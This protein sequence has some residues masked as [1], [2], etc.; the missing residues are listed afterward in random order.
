MD[1]KE[2]QLHKISGIFLYLYPQDDVYLHVRAKDGDRNLLTFVTNLN[3]LN[4][5]SNIEHTEKITD[6]EGIGSYLTIKYQ[7]A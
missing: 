7:V 1:T 3:V 6:D 4:Q 5:T 2:L